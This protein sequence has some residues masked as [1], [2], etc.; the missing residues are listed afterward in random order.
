MSAMTGFQGTTGNTTGRS[1]Y[2]KKTPP[3][4][5]SGALQQMPPESLELFRQLFSHVGPDSRLSRLAA[6]DEEMFN[7][8]EAPAMKQFAGLQGNIASRFS[9]MGSAARRSSGFQNTMS[10]AA[11]DFAS[12]LQSQRMA[13]SNQAMKDLFGMSEML[14]GQ[15]PMEQFLTPKKMPFWKEYLLA[16]NERG[17]EMAGT[18]GKMAALGAF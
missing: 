10:S 8:L 16:L 6:G 1:Y 14:M 15:R 4:Y 3:G 7:Q 12:Q 5:R 9:G 17:Q 11:Q 2:D 13:L 18:V